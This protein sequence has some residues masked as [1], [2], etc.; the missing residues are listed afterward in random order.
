[1]AKKH[2]KKAGRARRRGRR[3]RRRGG[4][5]GQ[6]IVVGLAGVVLVMCAASITWGFFL[7]RGDASRAERLRVEVLNGTGR[8]GLAHAARR[9]LLA[10]GVDVVS[11]GNAD[12]F[13]Y[14]ASIVVVR[15]RDAGVEAL[16]RAIGCER[17]VEQIDED[18]LED[19]EVILG[20]DWERLRLG[21]G[22]ADLPAP[23]R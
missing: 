6:K 22:V 8:S 3:S 23:V 13:D 19:A 21:L 17:V 10:R 12:R 15:H 1:M 9:A 20:A 5:L 16:A 2:S 11:V 4:S 18:A 7:R 14:D